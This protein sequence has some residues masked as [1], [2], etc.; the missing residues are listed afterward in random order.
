MSFEIKINAGQKE[1]QEVFWNEGGW[2]ELSWGIVI[3]LSPLKTKPDFF[4]V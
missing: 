4:A 3:R 2:V 1:I